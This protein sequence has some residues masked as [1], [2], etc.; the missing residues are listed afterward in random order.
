MPSAV[1]YAY[2]ASDLGKMLDNSNQAGG[3]DELGVAVAF[4]T[5][6]IADGKGKF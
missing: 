6:S 2:D 5:P 4:V 1:L 3:R